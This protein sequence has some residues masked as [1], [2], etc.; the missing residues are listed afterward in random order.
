MH[1][2]IVGG[3]VAGTACAQTLINLEHRV[4]LI[5]PYSLKVLKISKEP[6][7]HRSELLKKY[8]M[9]VIPA[10]RAAHISNNF[11]MV[12]DRNQL[13]ENFTWLQDEVANVDEN[14]RM[15]QLKKSSTEIGYDKICYCTGAQPKKLE[16]ELAGSVHYLRDVDS[17]LS[18]SAD[19]DN[20]GENMAVVGSGGIAFELIYGL[21]KQRKTAVKHLYW[22]LNEDKTTEKYFDEVAM[23]F[24]L[25][26]NVGNCI[27]TES[28]M[29]QNCHL[30]R[31]KPH[32]KPTSG[33]SVGGTD[34]HSV[35]FGQ[36]KQMTT[37]VQLHL[38]KE[39][40]T[41]DLIKTYKCD[42]TCV[43]IGVNDYLPFTPSNVVNMN[44][45]LAHDQNSY[46]AGDCC[47]LDWPEPERPYFFQMKLWSQAQLLGQWAAVC[48][49]HEQ[50]YL[51]FT[52]N[53]FAHMTNFFGYKVVYLGLYRETED[54]SFNYRVT[55]GLEY[56]KLV[57]RKGRVIGAVL[58]GDTDMEEVI[59]MLIQNEIDISMLE[60][61]LLNPDIDLDHYFD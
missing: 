61:D 28:S 29:V 53:T 49:D 34:W 46:A 24:L 1:V 56:V 51:D 30:F 60:E 37:G 3:G 25:D 31:R 20:C 47:Q 43:A 38:I 14:R 45:Q 22:F 36:S 42:L 40:V 6:M 35:L 27:P 12:L 15:V 52:F 58:I 26:E 13:H 33:S 54:V 39:P 23:A 55:K 17:V 50:P 2:V 32:H 48:I 59:E 21:T 7:A 8:E 16:I 5:S 4:T 9:D 10:A 18:L 44:M 41:K 11:E 19:L 57:L